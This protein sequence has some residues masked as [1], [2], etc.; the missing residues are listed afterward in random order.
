MKSY[1]KNEAIE[2]L[3]ALL[4]NYDKRSLVKDLATLAV[5]YADKNNH[6]WKFKLD[7]MVVAKDNNKFIIKI[8]NET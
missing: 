5:V 3:E 6:G 1:E 2:T 4:V 8:G 7:D